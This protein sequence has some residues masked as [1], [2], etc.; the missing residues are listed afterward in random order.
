M[1]LYVKTIRGHKDIKAREIIVLEAVSLPR[2]PSP[3]W[4]LLSSSYSSPY[5]SAINRY[6]DYASFDADEDGR[7]RRAELMSQLR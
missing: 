3:T 1:Q 7:R 2:R 5:T 4:R 6:Y